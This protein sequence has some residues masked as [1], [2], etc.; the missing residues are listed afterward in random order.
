MNKQG[1]YW[2]WSLGFMLG[3]LL[4]AGGLYLVM[5]V[6]IKELD[7]AARKNASGDFIELSDGWVHY[8]FEGL[9]SGP[10]VVLV[11]GFS[12]PAYIWDPTFQALADAGYK[13]LSFDLYGRGYSDR[14]D[15]VYDID[16]LI[17]SWKIFW[18]LWK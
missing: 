9:E 17:P 5:P 18:R 15:K 7:A 8:H 11:H 2:R 1:R 4:L 3:L 12:V 13:V 14:P 6:E 16:L 10:A